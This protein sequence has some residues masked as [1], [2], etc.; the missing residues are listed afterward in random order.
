MT[1][2]GF[3]LE[4]AWLG[5]VR[6]AGRAIAGAWTVAAASAAVFFILSLGNGLDAYLAERLQS[7]TPALWVDA[8]ELAPGARG[9]QGASE[10]RASLASLR[11]VAAV[12]RTVE[13]TVLASRE[14]RSAAAKI[15]GYEPDEL[16]RVL[17]VPESAVTGRLPRESGEAALGAELARALGARPG[18]AVRLTGPSGRSAAVEVVGILHAGFAAVDAALVLAAFDAAADVAAESGRYGYAV[19]VEGGVDAEAL[20]LEVQKATGRWT[21]VWYE[22]RRALLEAVEVEARVMF[23]ISL[24]AVAAAALGSSG[25]A[26]LRAAERRAETGVLLALGASR[27]NLLRAALAESVIGAS[28][29]AVAGALL[30][31]AATALLARYPLQLPAAFGLEYLPVRPSWPGFLLSAGLTVAAT[32]AAAVAPALRAARTDPVKALRQR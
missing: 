16:L 1:T 6:R 14:G 12:S 23:W 10:I 30:G 11:G 15:A 4:M 3:D 31:L 18:D 13:G 20:R 25:V 19:A 26:A 8:A 9:A 5:V 7:F 32:C 28:A 17:P 22:G 29:A 24:A 27:V 2:F 21:Q